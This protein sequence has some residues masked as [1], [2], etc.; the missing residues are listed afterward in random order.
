MTI[1]KFINE[2]PLQ[3]GGDQHTGWLPAGAA[4]P[5][6]TPVRDIS[7]NI[8]IEFDGYGYFLCFSS[9]DGSVYGD[10]WHETLADAEQ[11][12]N[13]DFGIHESEWRSP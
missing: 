4:T 5:L 1:V 7:L 12:A 10:T 8:Q 11:A 13:E 6:P 3:I 2:R 9:T